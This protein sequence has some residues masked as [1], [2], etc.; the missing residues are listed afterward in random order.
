MRETQGNEQ[1][2]RPLA[3]IRILNYSHRIY[4][5]KILYTLGQY[6]IEEVFNFDDPTIHFEGFQR[7]P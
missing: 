5:N 6:R 2:S 1:L 3:S 7:I 4:P